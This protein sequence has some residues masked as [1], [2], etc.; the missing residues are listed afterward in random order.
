MPGPR[1][2][3]ADGHAVLGLDEGHVVDDEDAG[4]ANLLQLVDGRFRAFDPIAASIECPGAAEGTIPGAAP[5]ELDGGTRVEHADEV[6]AAMPQKIARGLQI[7]EALDE[8]GGGPLPGRGHDAGD[9][10]QGPR[11]ALGGRFEQRSNRGLSFS[12]ENAGDR[13]LA[14]F[15]KLAEQ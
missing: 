3:L 6:L 7:V 12:L 10:E 2:R 5:A 15:Q 1:D 4:L 14:V 9:F 8:S 13:T 11:I